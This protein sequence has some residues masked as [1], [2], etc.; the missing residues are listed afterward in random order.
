MPV[1][2]EFDMQKW[3]HCGKHY[4]D[5][6]AKSTLN[7]FWKDTF[8]ALSTYIDKY[9]INYESFAELTLFYNNKLLIGNKSIFLNSWFKAGVYYMGVMFDSYESYGAFLSLED[10]N[11]ILRLNANFLIFHGIKKKR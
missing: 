3:F 6:I 8:N 4:I 11:N 7:V 1:V 5:K 10:F 2:N 9:P